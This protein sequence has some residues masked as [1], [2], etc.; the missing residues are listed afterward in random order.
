M[1]RNRFGSQSGRVLPVQ[2]KVSTGM[3]GF[4]L[5][6]AVLDYYIKAFAGGDPPP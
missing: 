6:P 2:P 4:A 1:P 3:V 5:N